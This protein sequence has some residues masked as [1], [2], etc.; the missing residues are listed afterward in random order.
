MSEES[1]ILTLDLV[2]HVY[3]HS[4]GYGESMLMRLAK[5]H[6][7]SI[8][9]LTFQYRMNEEICQLSSLLTYDG[10]LKCGN[11]AVAGRTLDLPGFPKA[12]P[13]I[14]AMKK[15]LWPWL[16]MTVSPSKPVLFVDTDSMRKS[17]MASTAENGQF[18]GLEEKQGGRAGG[19][20]TNPTEASIV[21]YIIH[22]LVAAGLSPKDIGVISPFRAQ[23]RLSIPY[24]LSV[25]NR[26]ILSAHS[27]LVQVHLL[28]EN[29]TMAD[30]VK[31]G[32][33]ISTIDRYQ[34]RDKPAILLSFVRSNCEGS[35]GRLLQ[36]E[37]R[38][39]V[40]LTR[41]KAKL[42]LVGSFST[43]KTGSA[44]LAPLLSLADAK[45]QRQLLPENALQCYKFG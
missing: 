19:K 38:L 41:A 20:V 7:S 24:R 26:Q 30:W 5:A 13:P 33:E 2:P 11:D 9:A 22:G 8:A 35:A 27:L 44:P 28:A 18:E 12:L 1:A 29:R 25:R 31:A 39:N 10:I 4:L 45:Q 6:P 3:V 32:L 23:V 15:G 36:D 17:P 34:G 16:R 40:A 43:L 42:I 21:L 37:R 14:A